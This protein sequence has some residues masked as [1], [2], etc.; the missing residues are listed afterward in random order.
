[1]NQNEYDGSPHDERVLQDSKHVCQIKMRNPNS[2][3]ST[4]KTFPILHSLFEK[5]KINLNNHD[6]HP[7]S[8]N[9]SLECNSLP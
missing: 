5:G 3:L 4:T 9:E 6:N 2:I 8:A 7:Q 1:M